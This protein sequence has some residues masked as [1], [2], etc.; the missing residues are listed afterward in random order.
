TASVPYRNGTASVPYGRN[1][2]ASVPYVFPGRRR[3]PGLPT[4]GRPRADHRLHP[5]RTGTVPALPGQWDEGRG[6][7]DEGRGTRDEGRGSEIANCKLQVANCEA[8]SQP[9]NQPTSASHLT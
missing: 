7:R 1:G 2:T 3:G 9:A 8:P 4:P 5:G 6:T